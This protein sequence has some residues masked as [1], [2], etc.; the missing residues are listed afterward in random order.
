MGLVHILTVVAGCDCSGLGFTPSWIPLKVWGVIITT[1]LYLSFPLHHCRAL[2][3]VFVVMYYTL[4]W[5]DVV[6]YSLTGTTH[7]II[8]PVSGIFSML[9]L[10]A[11]TTTVVPNNTCIVSL[12][13][14]TLYKQL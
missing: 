8:M 1:P 13:S 7:L 11:S 10:M 9:T 2:H 14:L 12:T 5:V 4:G 6:S 3:W